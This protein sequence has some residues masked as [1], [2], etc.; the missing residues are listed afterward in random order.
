MDEADKEWMITVIGVSGWM[1]LLVPAHLGCP[2]QNPESR[3]T[4]VCVWGEALVSEIGWEERLDNDLFSVE[5]D[6]KS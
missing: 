1:F 3:K 4:V 5:W 6:V 2:G